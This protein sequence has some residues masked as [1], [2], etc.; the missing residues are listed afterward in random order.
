MTYV[1]C[2]HNNYAWGDGFE[3]ERE[4]LPSTSKNW[5]TR[6]NYK[7]IITHDLYSTRTPVF[8]QLQAN[9]KPITTCAHNLSN[10][11]R[12]LQ[13][14]ARNSHW[15]ITLFALVVIGQSYHFGIVFWQSFEKPLYHA[16]C[17]NTRKHNKCFYYTLAPKVW[18]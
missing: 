16:H 8:N 11:L 12:K 5:V 14:I 1:R 17:N 13:V 15:F 6:S 2:I 10:T 3:W 9:L 7:I 4:C 18:M